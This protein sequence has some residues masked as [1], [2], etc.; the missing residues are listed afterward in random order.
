MMSVN[1]CRELCRVLFA[2][3]SLARTGRRAAEIGVAHKLGC[4]GAGTKA[5]RGMVVWLVTGLAAVSSAAV[6][7]EIPRAVYGGWIDTANE[8]RSCSNVSAAADVQGAPDI[9]LIDDKDG[10]KL[11][12]VEYEALYKVTRARKGDRDDLVIDVTGIGYGLGFRSEMRG[13]WILSDSRNNE[14]LLT[15]TEWTLSDIDDDGN[16]KHFVDPIPTSRTYIRCRPR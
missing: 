14:N 8:K 11:V 5:P 13:L 1:F 2:L 9:D 16:F 10:I 12:S 15:I 7:Q 4:F 3:L 6:A